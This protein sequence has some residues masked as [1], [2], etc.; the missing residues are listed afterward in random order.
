MKKKKKNEVNKT[1][2]TYSQPDLNQGC[3]D[4][5]ACVLTTTLTVLAGRDKYNIHIDKRAL[6]TVEGSWVICTREQ[7]RNGKKY[8]RVKMVHFYRLLQVDVISKRENSL[9]YI[10]RQVNSLAGLSSL[11]FFA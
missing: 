11:M 2:N 4:W 10:G 8:T 5:K 7:N 3:P 6:S 9:V 1:I